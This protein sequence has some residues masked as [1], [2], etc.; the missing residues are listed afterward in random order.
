MNIIVKQ[1]FDKSHF[2]TV[3][4]K[5]YAQTCLELFNFQ[6]KNDLVEND[7]TS[8]IISGKYKDT[9]A[10]IISKQSGVVAGIEEV[11]YLINEKTNLTVKQKIKDREKIKGNDLLLELTGSPLEIL[12]YE[13]TILNILQRMSGIATLTNRLITSHCLTTPLATT[14]KTLW[15][16]LDKKAV[17]VGGGLTHRLSLSDE[18][19]IKDNHIGLWAN[20]FKVS[21]FESLKVIMDNIR[22]SSVKN[23]FE[24]EVESEKEAIYLANYYFEI[25]ITAPL[26]IMLDNFEPL[27]ALRTIKT[28]R[29]QHKSTELVFELSGGINER[30]IKKYDQVGAD[31]ISLGALTHSSKALDISL[32]LS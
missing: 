24:I 23:P 17:S 5:T 3:K 6:I 12:K 30:N 28:I 14:R 16:L 7:I 15:G 26:I 11:V 20:K 1:Y 4:N 18:I 25:D 21:R 13:R 8:K 29:N 2:L 19:L 31:V 32:S 9:K 27:D 22:N 10:Q